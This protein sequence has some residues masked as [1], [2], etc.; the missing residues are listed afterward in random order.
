MLKITQEFLDECAGY[1]FLPLYSPESGLLVDG[2]R[3]NWWI[4]VGPGRA[5]PAAWVN[6]ER[7]PIPRATAEAITAAGAAA[8]DGGLLLPGGGIADLDDALNLIPRS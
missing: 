1:T 5:R 6:E 8:S 4:T 7:R 2:D 3:F